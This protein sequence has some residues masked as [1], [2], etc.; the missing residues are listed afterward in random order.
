MVL[1]RTFK[2][3]NSSGPEKDLGRCSTAAAVWRRLTVEED[4]D[5]AWLVAADADVQCGSGGWRRG[6][7]CWHV[8]R[9]RSAYLQVTPHRLKVSE[10]TQK[11]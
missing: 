4:E 3:L 11:F 6:G 8:G 5:E 7:W 9:L 10:E 2:C 1:K